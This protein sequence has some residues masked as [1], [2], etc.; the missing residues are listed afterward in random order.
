[1]NIAKFLKKAY[2]EVNLWTA[3][4]EQCR[5]KFFIHLFEDCK[6]GALINVQECPF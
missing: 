5:T 2:F 6:T 1:M 4:S 3:A